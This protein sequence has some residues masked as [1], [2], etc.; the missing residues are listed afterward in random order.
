M[1]F[2]VYDFSTGLGPFISFNTDEVF[3]DPL[4]AFV[5]LC[6]GQGVVIICKLVIPV[7]SFWE[8]HLTDCFCFICSLVQFSV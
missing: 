7:P 5:H 2:T 1:R 8:V 6:F 3:L 4:F